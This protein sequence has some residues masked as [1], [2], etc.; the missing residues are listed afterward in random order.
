MTAA[1]SV[2]LWINNDKILYLVYDD[3]V[4]RNLLNLMVVVLQS[5]GGPIG[6]LANLAVR[7]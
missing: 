1:G 4:S 5:L 3:M 6:L 7:S 2:E